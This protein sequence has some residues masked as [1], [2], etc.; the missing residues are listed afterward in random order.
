MT[1]EAPPRATGPQ[2]EHD[3]D[4]PGL[5]SVLLRWYAAHH[6]QLPWRAA[7]GTHPDPYA[8]WISEVM[9]QQTQVA[10]ATPYFQRWMARF[11]TLEALAAASIDE[12]L[13]LWQGLGYYGRA[14][15]LHEAARLLLTRGGG[16]PDDPAALG[17]L[18]GVGDYTAGA[19]LSIAFG[20]AHPAIDGNV[21]RVLGR[22]GAIPGDLKRGVGATRLRALAQGLLDA[23]APEAERTGDRDTAPSPGDLNQALMELGA[24]LCRPRAPDCGA[25]PAAAFCL[26]RLEGRAEAFPQAT[27][28]ARSRS[29]SGV[30]YAVNDGLGR[31]LM[32]RRRPDGLLGGLWEFPWLESPSSDDGL[33]RL[34]DLWG[35]WVADLEPLD[36][37]IRHAFTHLRLELRLLRG[38]V[39]TVAAPA[40]PVAWAP[41]VEWRWVALEGPERQSLPMSRL[42][43]KLR[44][45]L[46]GS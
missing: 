31:W 29:A 40:V 22:I 11:P 32:G 17:A 16:I 1:A 26:A 4:L 38:A 25:C 30:A 19:L 18:P 44:R 42:M 7:P 12:V 8:V 24:R 9:L 43:D 13:Q 14:R 37:P 28:R 27:S 39:A 21:R 3:L 46:E 36:P 20:Q 10:T 41:Y 15:R 5:R 33:A 2:A 6:R 23:V 35:P 34:A 45:R